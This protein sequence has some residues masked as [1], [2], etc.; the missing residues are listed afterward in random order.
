M[1]EQGRRLRPL[2]EQALAKTAAGGLP[3]IHLQTVCSGT[4]APA[5]ALRLVS[6]SLSDVGVKMK[7]RHALSCE[8]EPFKQAYIAVSVS[9]FLSPPIAF[10]RLSLFTSLRGLP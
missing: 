8:N 6:D 4:D 10:D 2:L 7:V 1:H 9:I 3:P 5:L